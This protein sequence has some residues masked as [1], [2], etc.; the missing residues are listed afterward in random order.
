MPSSKGRGPA[1]DVHGNIEDFALPDRDQF[2][3]SHRILKVQ[4]AQRTVLGKGE[5]VL[6]K[7]SIDPRFAIAPLI[8]RLQKKSPVIAKDI[9][10]D[11]QEVV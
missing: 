11:E 1:S 10:F 8:P 3:L 2:A 9:R 6:H 7:R 5:I 4:S